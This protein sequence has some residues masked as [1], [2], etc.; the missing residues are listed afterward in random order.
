[1]RRPAT[2]CVCSALAIESTAPEGRIVSACRKSNVA[3]RACC[4][5]RFSW[6]ARCRRRLRTTR[7]PEIV[8]RLVVESELSASTTMTSE[9][10]L[11]E[12]AAAIVSPKPFAS[13]SAGIIIEMLGSNADA[14]LALTI[15][16]LNQN[17]PDSSY[18]EKLQRGKVPPRLTGA[19][20][21]TQLNF[22]CVIRSYIFFASW[23]AAS[24]ASPTTSGTVANVAAAAIRHQRQNALCLAH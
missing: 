19:N 16:I 7:A 10:T 13:F 20:D 3:A 9:G 5:P 23:R 1:M 21:Q 6:C 4:A 15:V 18:S 22:T 11:E 2:P 17:R 14:P 8:A 12:R 24:A